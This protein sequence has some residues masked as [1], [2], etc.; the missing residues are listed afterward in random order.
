MDTR[1]LESFVAVADHGSLAAAAHRLGLTPAAITQRIRVLEDEIGTR[2]LIRSGRTVTTTEAGAAILVRSRNVLVE[3]RDLKSLAADST[4]SGELRLGAVPSST[5]G[6]LPD[7]LKGMMQKHPRVVFSLTRGQ[8]PDLYRRITRGELDA[9]IIAAPP[10]T[11]PKSCGWRTL[12]E[13]PFVLLTPQSMPLRSLRLILRQ[14]PFIR[15][16]RNGWTGRIVD[17]YLRKLNIRPRHRFEAPGIAEIAVLVDRGVG[18][19]IVPD[20]RVHWPEGLSVRKT[21]F[22]DKSFL[23]RIGLVW[24]QAS[25]RTRLVRAFLDE[26]N[27]VLAHAHPSRRSSPRTPQ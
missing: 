13:E 9:A 19:S 10:F 18:V 12:V 11:I 17:A 2:L 23:R 4:L 15:Q 27:A 16:P 14:E 25:A 20:S 8:A 7:A 3:I 6:F 5:G 1:F 26:V 24:A 22:R 21:P